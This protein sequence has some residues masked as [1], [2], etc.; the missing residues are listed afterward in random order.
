MK[1][2]LGAFCLFPALALAELPAL[3]AP[4]PT[5]LAAAGPKGSTPAAKPE[6]FIAAATGGVDGELGYLDGGRLTQALRRHGALGRPLR[7]L[8]D[9][10][11][12]DTR[13]EG[14]RLAAL[15]PSVQVRWADDAGRPQRRLWADSK[16]LLRWRPGSEPRWDDAGAAAAAL[17]FEARWA[18]A[19]LEPP[20]HLRLEDQLQALPN[21]YEQTPHITRRR[22]GVA[23]DESHADAEDP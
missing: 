18:R 1:A 23:K 10:R 15:S 8:L 14:L 13:R 16:R 17:D 19:A 2:L 5:P 4:E 12:A 6:D 22:E 21:P 11:S 20:R 7:L 9:P 3:P